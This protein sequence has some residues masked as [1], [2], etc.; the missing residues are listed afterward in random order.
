LLRS[1]RASS[2]VLVLILTA[3]LSVG[4]CSSI[5]KPKA[6]PKITYKERPVD[7]LY[8]IASSYL[9]Q[10]AW[11]P[12]IMY[13]REVERQHPYSEWARRSIMMG[14]YANYRAHNYSEAVSESDRFV[15]LYPGNPSAAYAHYLKAVCYFEQIVDVGRDQGATEQAQVAL[16]EVIRRYPDSPYARD[17]QLKLDMVDDQLAGKEMTVGRFYL[18]TGDTVAA[19]GRF[20]SV[21]DHYGTTSH[22][23]EALY[24]MVEAYLT[25]GVN[26]EAQRNA[27]VLG[28]NFPGSPWYA[29]AYALMNDRGQTMAVTPT[30]GPRRLRNLFGLGRSSAPAPAPA[31]KP[32]SPAIAPPA[33]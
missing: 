32:S 11:Q 9:D 30:G 1:L 6:A 3:A 23:P 18:R 27:A 14:A 13:Y 26:M 12:A 4:G 19:I 20:R 28:A 15:Q 10:G 17:A 5:F 2:T 7:L 22:A 24:R 29:D 25:L 16:R 31:A 21:I 8:N 33:S